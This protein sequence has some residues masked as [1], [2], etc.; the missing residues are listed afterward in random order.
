MARALINSPSV[1]FAD[2]PSGN[3][4]SSSAQNLHE[5]FIKLKEE[6][7]TSLAIKSSCQK[8]GFILK[9]N[10]QEIYSRKS[11]RGEG[12]GLIC[13]ECRFCSVESV[14]AL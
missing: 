5:L 3:L 1:I 11:I 14:L 2:E 8:D 4:D 6:D 12:L 7:R 10:F 9:F 13:A